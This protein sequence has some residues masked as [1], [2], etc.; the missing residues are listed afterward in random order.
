MLGHPFWL[1][2]LLAGVEVISGSDSAL[3]FSLPIVMDAVTC[4]GTETTLG[5]SMYRGSNNLRSCSHSED[6][7]I[8]CPLGELIICV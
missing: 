7:R 6:V 8:R 4:N 3:I 1:S 5:D 2:L